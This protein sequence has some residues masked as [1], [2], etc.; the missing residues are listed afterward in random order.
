ME[1]ERWVKRVCRG[2]RHVPE[3]HPARDRPPSGSTSCCQGRVRVTA[4]PALRLRSLPF[5][6]RRE[7]VVPLPRIRLK[8]RR[9]SHDPKLRVFHK[10]V[11]ARKRTDDEPA[12]SVSISLLG[13]IGF[14]EYDQW[15]NQKICRIDF[16]NRLGFF[17]G[18]ERGVQP[19]LPKMITYAP[20]RE[21][22]NVPDQ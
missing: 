19:E 17:L 20:L 5:H 16:L 14:E 6:A 15:A 22:I 21:M 10:R 1:A 18:C 11:H 3:R 7:S 2:F 4:D 9:S 12:N 13:Q 8:D